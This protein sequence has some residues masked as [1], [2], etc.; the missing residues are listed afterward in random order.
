MTD[1]A[2]DYDD[3]LEDDRPHWR[4][5]LI[6]LATL[7]IVAVVGAVALW[8]TVF[9]GGGT[10]AAQTQTT[11][12]TLG[13]ISKT[14]S[15]SATTLAQST[16]NLSFG[17]SGKV[18]AV[19]VKLGQAGKAGRRTGGDRARLAAKRRIE[20]AGEPGERAGKAEHTPARQHRVTAH[21]GGPERGPGAG[22]LRSGRASPAGPVECPRGFS[23][24]RGSTVRHPSAVAAHPGPERADEA[25][26][27]QQR[28]RHR[29]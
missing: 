16:A 23:A 2:E 8:A 13:T 27:H 24:E 5:R 9:R 6:V 21:C 7:L 17:A 12:V 11:K 26:H 25:G 14:I 19:N 15:T 10:T 18:T 3:F 29:R 1:R 22:N 4:R 28:R 20:C